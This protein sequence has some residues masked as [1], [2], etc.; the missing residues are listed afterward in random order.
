METFNLGSEAA[1]RFQQN[2]EMKDSS[3]VQIV[4]FANNCSMA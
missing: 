2:M 3:M 1:V 4:L